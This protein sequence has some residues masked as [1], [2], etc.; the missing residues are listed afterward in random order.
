MRMKVKLKLFATL[1]EY[2]PADSAGGQVM[3][4]LP[5]TATVPDALGALGVPM[6]LTHI[7]FVNGRHVLRPERETFR[8]KDGD[9]LSAFPAIGGG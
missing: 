6:N 5:D 3:L 4:E 2:L 1:Q 7:L 8:L 9:T